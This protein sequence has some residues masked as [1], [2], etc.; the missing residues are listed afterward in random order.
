MKEGLNLHI[1]YIDLFLIQVQLAVVHCE[2][3]YM[4]VLSRAL[5]NLSS[6]ILLY[7]QVIYVQNV[8]I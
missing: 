6:Q 7:S 3:R 4:I 5:F 1:S 8:Q 2:D